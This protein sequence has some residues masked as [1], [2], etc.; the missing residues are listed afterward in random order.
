MNHQHPPSK[1]QANAH[2]ASL[3]ARAFYGTAPWANKKTVFWLLVGAFMLR[4]VLMLTFPGNET[5]VN[6]FIAWSDMLVRE[7][8]QNFY[9][10]GAFADYPPGYLYF[11]WGLG[12][13]N[14]L[15]GFAYPS[16]MLVY[17]LGLPSLCADLALALLL[18][19]VARPAGEKAALTVLS[20]TAFAPAF[21]FNT[22]IWKQVDSVLMLALCGCFLLLQKRRYF[23]SAGVYALAVLL[24]PQAL[25]LGPVFALCF[26]F[27]I[28]FAQKGQRLHKCLI[29]AGCAVECVGLIWLFALPFQ[30][31]QEPFW[32]I[33]RYVSTTGSYPYASVNAYNLFAL[34]GANWQAQDGGW[35]L[36][37]WQ[38]GSLLLALLTAAT[39]WLAYK[40]HKRQVINWPLLGAFYG[41]GVFTLMHNM[42]ERYSFAPFALLL[43][44]YALTGARRLYTC[45]LLQGF[46]C[47]ANVS[48]AY[49]T[50]KYNHLYTSNLLNACIRMVS[51]LQVLSFVLLALQTLAFFTGIGE[52][53]M[54]RAANALSRRLRPL[55]AFWHAIKEKDVPNAPLKWTWQ[56]SVYLLIPMLVCAAISFIG[57]GALQVPQSSWV[58]RDI[59]S[60]SITLGEKAGSVSRVFAY[61]G[62]TDGAFELR[63]AGGRKLAVVPAQSG[64]LYR[65]HGVDVSGLPQELV[66]FAQGTAVHE[67]VFLD[68]NG[69]IIT[70]AAYPQAVNALFD[71]QALCPNAIRS[72]DG[73][74]FD[75]IYHARS[76]YE[77][78][79]GLP[80]YETT[81]PPL[82]KALISVGIS[83]FGM[84]PFGWRFMGALFGVLL[85]G[86]L[87]LFAR[88]LFGRRD[89][90]LTASLL[91]AFDFMRFVQSRI[92]T[93]DVF[94]AFFIVA[95]YYFMLHY[96]RADF[97]HTSLRKLF[98][99]LLG[100]GICFALAAAVKWTGFYA[101]AGLAVLFFLSLWQNARGARAL[102]DA[103]G[104][105]KRCVCILAFCVLAFVLIPI[106]IYIASY[107]PIFKGADMPLTIKEVWLS[108]RH[109][110]NYHS[111][112]LDSHPFASRWYEWPLSLRPVWYFMGEFLPAGMHASIALLGNPLVW[113]PACA[114]ALLLLYAKLH[115]AGRTAGFLLI[116]AAAQLLPWMFVTRTTFLYHYM[117]TFPF[118]LFML[119]FV[120][121]RMEQMAPRTARLLRWLLPVVSVAMFAFFYPVLAGVPIKESYA[122][123]LH[124]LPRWG[125]YIF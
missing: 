120:L 48:M 108:Q 69:N 73:M 34:F 103:R 75:E 106:G 29:A 105:A 40:G 44:A 67:L 119:C 60:V 77:Q 111:A 26:L 20:F 107:L 27:A 92:A 100:S 109:M 3:Q 76:A 17:V 116:A 16:R 50:L 81:H 118:V 89:F 22:A 28:V 63:D 61:M 32:L 41:I 125:F 98:A 78:L 124:W 59:V 90:A 72:I 10:S 42:H 56:D 82:G 54:E 51:F 93:I 11:L 62:Y 74:Y 121:L 83:I 4:T 65:W 43:L 102:P 37:Y 49:L 114:A 85:V 104:F 15:L 68:A 19:H 94:S 13:V 123:L 117:A 33:Q 97:Y 18:W 101:G 7:G 14:K 35:L 96:L 53:K 23:A 84:N 31:T 55:H 52:E 122:K 25:I 36:Q 95:A 30:G 80:I 70:P 21:L 64:A 58:A 57:L 24:K 1:R 113:W 110:W 88:S 47:F 79:K 12:W 45:A 99:P 112:L 66:L 115:G 46:C 71:E 39:V 5:D 87:Y 6:C 9:T 38:W 2:S 8:P 91:Y 86:L